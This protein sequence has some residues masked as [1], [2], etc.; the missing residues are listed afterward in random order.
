MCLCDNKIYLQ[1]V[2]RVKR[3]STINESKINIT[4]NVNRY[5]L[6]SNGYEI[7]SIIVGVIHNQSESQSTNAMKKENTQLY[8]CLMGIN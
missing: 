1:S 8:N 5:G 3:V 4:I 2:L 7:Q 6:M